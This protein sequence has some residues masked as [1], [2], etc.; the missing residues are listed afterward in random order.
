MPASKMLRV[1]VQQFL[2]KSRLLGVAEK[3]RYLYKSRSL[4]KSNKRFIQA[5]PDF[6]L[7]PPLLAFDAYSAPDW[8][9]YKRSGEG[10]A[11][12]LKETTARYFGNNLQTIYEWGCGPARV[13]RHLP[14]K[15]GSHVEVFG[16]DYNPDTIAWCR[17]NI[18]GI[19]FSL[20]QL[21]PPLDFADASFDFIYSISVFTHL[22][23]STGLQWANELQRVLRPGGILLITTSGS[24]AYET[25][26][27]STERKKYDAGGV[28]VRGDYEEGKKMYLARHNPK[29]VRETLL[30]QFNILEH[31]SAGFPFIEQDYWLAQKAPV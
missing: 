17:N 6:K 23:E 9:F 12:F 31:V 15:L 24:N 4:E 2:R 5:Y 19:H 26:L 8:D 1:R 22:S 29:Y 11:H 13:I 7:P 16:S 28:V 25:E 10:T 21:S 14:G 20:N 27:L 30:R 18:P 3:F